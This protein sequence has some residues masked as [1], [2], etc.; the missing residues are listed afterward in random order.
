MKNYKLYNNV[1]GWFIFL[2]S[3]LVYLSTIE[4]TTSLWD[5]GEF[6][7]SAYKLEVG[8]PPGAPF[9]MLIG[10]FFSLFAGKDVSKVAMMINLIS[11]LASAFT[12][13]FLFWTITHMAKR[14]IVK[15]NNYTPAKTL[16]IIGSGLAGA[17]AYT[18]SDTFWFSAVE[19]EVYASSSL[20][21]AVVFWA[22]LKWENVADEKYADRWL[23]L[24]AYLMGLSIGV[25][26][27]NLLAIP[28]IALVYYFRK[29]KV[30]PAG[31][32]IALFIS[33]FILVFIQ[34]GII[35]HIIEFASF[36]ELYFVNELKMPFNSG[37]VVF[38]FYL[39]VFIIT[40]LIATHLEGEDAEP[41]YLTSFSAL[42][43]VIGSFTIGPLLTAIFIIIYFITKRN[44]FKTVLVFYLGIVPGLIIWYIFFEGKDKNELVKKFNHLYNLALICFTVIIIGYSSYAPIIIRSRANPPMNENTPDNVF[45]LLSYLNREQYGD[46]PLFR[47]QYFNAMPIR[48]EKGDP[49]YTKINGRYEITNYKN[50]Y[51]YDNKYITLFPRMYSSSNEHID[52]YISW[53]G[54]KE[55]DLYE[56]RMDSQGN[57]MRDRKGQIAYD[58][59]MPKKAPSFF[60]NI[61]FL[62]K[63]QIG[64]M[65][66]RYFMWNFVGRQ[67]DDQGYGDALAGNW[68]SGIPF[69]DRAFVGSYKNM[70]DDI[71]SNPSRNKYYFLPLLLGLIGLLYHMQKDAKNFWVVTLLFILTGVAIVAYLNQTPLQPR[72]RDY[73]YAGSFYAFSIW[74]GIGVLGII[75]ILN[76]NL[77][78]SFLS[79]SI[80]VLC[81]LIVPGIMASE[82]WKDHNRSGR[83]TARDVAYNYLNSCAP[84]A[85]LFTN[86]DNDTFPLWYAQEVEG[87]RTD[88]RVVNLMLLNM[89]WYI[90]QMKIKA[91]ESDPL[92]I[93]LSGDKYRMGTRDVVYIID[94][95][96]EFIDLKEIMQF[97]ES[98]NERTKLKTH[99]GEQYSYI[100]TKNF[101]LPVDS[102]K[103]ISNGTV[104]PEDAD[105]IVK[106]INWT[107]NARYFG[108][109]ELIVLDILANNSWDRPVYFVSTGHEGMLNLEDYLQIEGLAYRL[110]PIKTQP[111]D[112]ISIGRI[113]TEI[114]YNNLM[115]RFIWRGLNDPDVYLD[116]YHVR[117]LSIIRLRHRFNMLA[118][119]LIK[120]GK[121]EKALEVLDK[122]VELTPHENV[123]YDMFMVSIAENYY[124]CRADDKANMIIDKYTDICDDYLTYYLGQNKENDRILTFMRSYFKKYFPFFLGQ[125]KKN[126][127]KNINEIQFYLQVLRNMLITSSLYGQVETAQRT[128]NIF[129][130][131][132]QVYLTQAQ[133][134]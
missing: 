36:Y 5:C 104:R 92:P 66:F 11:V 7:A 39:T 126:V 127:S 119:E 111:D 23:V 21:T 62:V 82:N 81:L 122:C 110:V 74:I 59:S 17:M 65:Y 38:F 3:A 26:L 19:G 34:S 52:T 31:I 91:Y 89:D 24:I 78:S 88:V 102:V 49:T 116:N 94:K 100:P 106:S 54:L 14:I 35:P 63:Y 99:T 1:T 15:E 107:I 97:V 125:N 50:R 45:S 22:I 93:T 25:H 33:A 47:G 98:D 68:I 73:A 112:Q 133:P 48:S 113:D 132:Y 120:E 55:G 8:H 129:N 12:I 86:G 117:T 83:Y 9:F 123:P 40:G 108:K 60:R 114:L 32:I 37:T 4:P 46:R 43:F 27:L 130:T 42:N 103:V 71:K 41:L 76:K 53:S 58:R 96:E 128:E 75:N 131:H 2:I 87:I 84:N 30:S 118:S 101:K 29:Y 16:A 70:P 124:R 6:I 64:H 67:N 44:L 121:P 77:R 80:T 95:I 51:I 105:K 109:S 13:M 56:P 72:E 18:F 61:A 57:V 20:F 85:I 90:D 134:E 69:I 79:A 115:N 28:A 10:R